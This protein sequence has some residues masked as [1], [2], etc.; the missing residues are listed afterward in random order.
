MIIAGIICI[1]FALSAV[2]F[3]A[4]GAM[5]FW[6]A[7]GSVLIGVGISRSKQKQSQQQTVIIN[8]YITQPSQTSES[9]QDDLPES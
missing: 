2:M 5:I 8:N 3:Q 6:A 9:Q 4:V 1:I 7:V